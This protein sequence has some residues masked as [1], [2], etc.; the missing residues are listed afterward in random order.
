MT[1]DGAQGHSA[2]AGP[3]LPARIGLL[4]CL[5]AGLLT[6][7]VATPATPPAAA[8]GFN[9]RCATISVSPHVVKIG[10]TFTATAARGS[11]WAPNCGDGWHWDLSG[12]YKVLS[13]CQD[14]ATL[15]ELKATIPTETHA[16]FYFS[17]LCIE[18][19]GGL[20]WDSCDTYMIVP[21]GGIIEGYV[22]TPSGAP[23]AGVFVE[24]LSSTTA[25]KGT[26]GV[27]AP[28][29]A[30]GITG[31]YGEYV[32]AALS[33]GSY[34]VTPSLRNTS[35]AAVPATFTPPS[36]GRTVGFDQV[37][38]ANFVLG[39]PSCQLKVF[40]KQLEP[41]RSGLAVHSIHYKQAPVDFM[42][43][44][45]PREG[46][47]IPQAVCESGCVDILVHV[48]E[49]K[50]HKAPV[51]YAT[52]SA[53]LGQLRLGSLE[54]DGRMVTPPAFGEGFLCVPSASLGGRDE[55][56]GVTVPGLRTDPEGEVR[57]RFWAPGVVA[58]A[59][60][61]LGVTAQ[62]AA[63][64]TAAKTTS[65]T[66]LHVVPYLVFQHSQQ[67]SV[68][69]LELLAD[70]AKG[71]KSFTSLLE[72]SVNEYNILHRALQI[73]EHDAIVA[74]Q[75]K[76]LLEAL[77]PI[78]PIVLTFEIPLYINVAYEA[79]GMFAVFL[80]DTGLSP[81]GIGRPPFEASVNA[82]PSAT[83]L[84]EL[85]NQLAVPDIFK[86]SDGGF[87]WASA[88][89]ISK[90]L[91]SETETGHLAFQDWSLTTKVYEVSHCSVEEKMGFCGPGYGNRPGSSVVTN[92][93]IQP[94]LVFVFTLLRGTVKLQ[95]GL[96]V[97]HDGHP[98]LANE[99]PV[100]QRSFAV[101]YDADAWT[102]TQQGLAGVIKDF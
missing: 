74:E 40:V 64:C 46:A 32:L 59:Y 91:A 76:E 21:P 62:C 45:E 53:T 6:G 84:H 88:Q 77:E 95:D 36:A 10:Q 85:I 80:E 52:V 100:L 34:T 90:E 66:T 56:C 93:G 98:V 7:T 86:A 73:F 18:G 25:A 79:M 2:L 54:I 65:H 44:T 70:W 1:G 42:G 68:E 8:Q 19:I 38:I 82:N 51:P 57:L 5:V 39:C 43:T 30:S 3:R 99:V 24:A 97:E 60:T 81:I 61:T 49:P 48:I 87:W 26:P 63:P 92:A 89:A 28:F 41:L 47:E 14:D 50:T 101:E 12:F 58:D 33:P 94:E 55:K 96:P 72:G 4:T 31:S 9:S 102:T 27:N 78:E 69:D 35:G 37:A 71:D 16:P 13:G 29:P 17:G 22:R 23:V 11:G 67:I 83:F 20:Q 75:A 15:C